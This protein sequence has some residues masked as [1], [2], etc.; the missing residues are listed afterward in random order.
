MA[1]YNGREVSFQAP[2]RDSHQSPAITVRYADG[3]LEN[4]QLSKV[5]F[6]EVEKKQL[7]KDYPS[8]YEGVTVIEKK[9]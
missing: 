9:K 5:Q 2:V 1:I 3:S 6:T 7:I 4:V 8:Q